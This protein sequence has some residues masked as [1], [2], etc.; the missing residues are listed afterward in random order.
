MDW[1]RT[2]ESSCRTLGT[3]SLLIALA[4]CG[5]QAG[6]D[7]RGEPL[8]RMRGQ[9][10]VSALTGGQAIE[11]ALCFYQADAPKPP[12]FEL[13]SKVP[14][15]IAAKLMHDG[16]PDIEAPNRAHTATHILAVESR[17]EFPAQFDIDVYV[18]P[19]ALGLS[20]PWVAGEPRWAAGQVC[21]VAKDHEAVTFPLAWGG[22]SDPSTGEFTIAIVSQ[23]HSRFYLESY[24]CADGA[25]AQNSATDC[26]RV[27]EGDPSFAY[28]FQAQEHLDSEWVL[29]NAREIEVVYLDE[30]APAGSFTAFRWGAEHGLSAGYHLFAVSP[31]RVD[32]MGAPDDWM[33]RA[34]AHTEAAREN[35][36][37]YGARIKELFGDDYIYDSLEAYSTL[38]GRS[39][40]LPEDIYLG[41][42]EVEMRAW[43]EHCPLQ[44]RTEID[45]ST[46]M[47]SIDISSESRADLSSHIGMVG[48]SSGEME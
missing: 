32:E 35:S 40:E 48:T 5:Q 21:A 37:R 26:T 38:A 43:M 42:R 9:A 1:A 6:D 14:A 45:P 13:T 29:G 17:G 25:M 3:A 2:T 22:H 27:R 28:E 19:P 30:A 44:P 12:P 46:A 20:A 39:V 47:L 16:E 10:V 18:P 7:Y 15:E 4:A 8:L 41:A 33:C 34:Q 23:L 11:P 31:Q 36:E 24:E